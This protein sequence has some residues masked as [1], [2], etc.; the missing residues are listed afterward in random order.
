VSRA[1]VDTCHA[2]NG[3][4]SC[5]AHVVEVVGNTHDVSGANH[6]LK[7]LDAADARIAT[8]TSTLHEKYPSREVTHE[9]Q[10]SVP[11]MA[12]YRRSM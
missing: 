9:R 7:M 2:L 12:S 5:D 3:E 8:C 11:V 1:V 6:E 10:Q 4:V